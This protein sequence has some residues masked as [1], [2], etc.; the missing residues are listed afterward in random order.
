MKYR[1]PKEFCHDMA[2][3]KEDIWEEGEILKCF[4][5]DPAEYP[6]QDITSNFPNIQ[7]KS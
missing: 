1:E 3:M 5:A 4:G 2:Y 7:F 6:N